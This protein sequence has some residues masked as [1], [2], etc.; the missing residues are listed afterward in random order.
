MGGQ[1]DR[2]MDDIQTTFRFVI[3][4][5]R[6]H[7]TITGTFQLKRKVPAFLARLLE[8]GGVSLARHQLPCEELAAA[9]REGNRLLLQ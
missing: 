2:Q 9:L 8:L 4:E 7:S 3:S 6:H 5:S 1:T